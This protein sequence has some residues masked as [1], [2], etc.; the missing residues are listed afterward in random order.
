MGSEPASTVVGEALP[1]HRCP[2]PGEGTWAD[3]L[4]DLRLSPANLMAKPSVTVPAV[5]MLYNHWNSARSRGGAPGVFDEAQRRTPAPVFFLSYAHTGKSRRQGP[6]REPNRAVLSFFDDLSENVAQLVARPAGA[7]AGYLDRPPDAGYMDRSI[8]AG[9]RWTN[10]LLAAVGTCQVFVALLSAPYFS[11]PWCGMEWH[12]FAQRRV[13]RN[14]GSDSGYSTGIFPVVW[15]PISAGQVP[16]HIQT[17]Q[18]FSP[19]GLPNSDVREQ[20]ET[21]GVFGLTRISGQEAYDA[22]VW[23]LALCIADFLS[24]NTVEPRTLAKE[25]LR[26]VFREKV[27]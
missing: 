25:E 12:A 6:P 18:R 20:Y 5:W 15:A 24:Y 2:Y 23:T 8:A 16:P 4:F 7:D 1:T 26:D 3:Y 17:V 19:A 27:S 13:V 10:Q 14:S 9:E 21:H 22:V 11:S